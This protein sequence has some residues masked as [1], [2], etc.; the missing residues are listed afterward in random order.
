MVDS[1]SKLN[2]KSTIKFLTISVIVF[3]FTSNAFSQVPTYNMMIANDTVIS[4]NVYE[5]DW[6]VQRTG[7]TPFE[8][9]SV[10]MGLGFN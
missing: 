3:V 9:A 6:Y 4:P 7:T 5:F 2:M 1:S 10:Q 8:L